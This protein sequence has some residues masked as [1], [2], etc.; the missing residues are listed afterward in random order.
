MKLLFLLVGAVA[1]A[2]ASNAQ[3]VTLRCDGEL[4]LYE[5]GFGK[6]VTKHQHTRI[7]TIDMKARTGT[8]NTLFG[9][10]SAALT[11]TA[12]DRWYAFDVQ[13]NRHYGGKII[14]SEM[15]SLNRYTGEVNSLYQLDPPDG[16]GMGYMAF[17]G[18]CQRAAP[19][20]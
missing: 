7:V 2:G 15:V 1:W 3:V 10:R 18:T 5:A 8:I 4:A 14:A 16:S 20:F 13:H 11:D 19:K 6:E 12:G 17:Q 9:E